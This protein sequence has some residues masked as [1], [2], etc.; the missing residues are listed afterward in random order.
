MAALGRRDPPEGQEDQAGGEAAKP[1][2][3]RSRQAHLD[4]RERRCRSIG[5]NSHHQTGNRPGEPKNAAPMTAACA[6]SGSAISA[7]SALTAPLST[8]RPSRGVIDRFSV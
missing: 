4:D 8:P 1:T 7:R 3:D 6:S 2:Y 5:E